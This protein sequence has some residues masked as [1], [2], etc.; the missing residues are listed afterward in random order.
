MFYRSLFKQKRESVI[1]ISSGIL[2]CALLWAITAADRTMT[3]D[4]EKEAVEKEVREAEQMLARTT[5]Q[6]RADQERLRLAELHF[7]LREIASRPG[8]QS[9]N[10][11]ESSKACE[12]P[13]SS[14][15][16]ERAKPVF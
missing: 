3:W 14:E 2:F 10:Y 5:D 15:N 16:A 8:K 1:V 6:A 12:G 9:K 13:I 7:F 11:L 4:Q